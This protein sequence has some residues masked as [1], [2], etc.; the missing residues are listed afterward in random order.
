MF[1][2]TRFLFELFTPFIFSIFL[3][4]FALLAQLL[5]KRKL[6]NTLLVSGL[7]IQLFCGYGLFVRNAV[8]NQEH[9]YPALTEAMIQSLTTKT[10]DYIVVL[11]SGHVSDPALPANSQIAGSSLYRLVEGI[12]LISYFPH[13]KLVVSGG[14]GYDP[15]PNAEIAK[16]VALSLGVAPDRILVENRPKDTLAEATMLSPLLREKEF[17]LVT[18]ATHMSRAIKIFTSKGLHPIAA[19][20]DYIIKKGQGKEPGSILP[21]TANLELSRRFMYEWVAEKWNKIKLHIQSFQ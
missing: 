18:S 3:Q 11:G 15:V 10:V 12:R 14:G 21:S 5:K 7:F 9:T 8:E 20:T 4:I 1:F 19:P 16:E 17:I 13:S 6:G 2:L